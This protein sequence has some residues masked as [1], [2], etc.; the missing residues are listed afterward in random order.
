VIAVDT[1]AWIELFRATGSPIHHTLRRLIEEDAEL[2]VTEVVVME[3]LSGARSPTHLNDLRNALLA[4]PVLPL[5]GLAGF[6]E[7]A[8]LYRA[9][10]LAGEV[11]PHPDCLVAASVIRADATVLSADRDF[12]AL[13]RH[14]SLRLQ[15]TDDV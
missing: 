9:C 7:A 6:E 3:V 5:H 2:A 15:A 4:F 13:A 1:S 12:E 10:R 11:V 14:T 8:E